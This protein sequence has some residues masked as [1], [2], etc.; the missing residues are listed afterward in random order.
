MTAGKRLRV[1][2]RLLSNRSQMTTKFVRT[3]KVED[4]AI[5]ESQ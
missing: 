5:V 1:A 3:K 2:M 4:E